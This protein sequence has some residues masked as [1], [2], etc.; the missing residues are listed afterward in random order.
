MP[1]GA[2]ACAVA[3]PT[4]AADAPGI[5]GAFVPDVERFRRD[6]EI[7]VP[8]TTLGAAGLVL[9]FVVVATA[10][11]ALAGRATDRR[12]RRPPRSILKDGPR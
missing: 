8:W 11:I 7:A 2:A 1:L 9:A 12:R 5:E 3:V 10:V 6:R 4:L